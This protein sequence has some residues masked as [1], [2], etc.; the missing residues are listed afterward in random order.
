[1]KQ[2]SSVSYTYDFFIVRDERTGKELY[3]VPFSVYEQMHAL[4]E[5]K[6]SGA[7]I[8]R[9]RALQS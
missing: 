4:M 8:R 3:R 5:D 9:C 2:G 6:E 7:L 1:M